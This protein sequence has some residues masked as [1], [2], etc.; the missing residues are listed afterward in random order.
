MLKTACIQAKHW[1]R[2]GLP[3][4]VAVNLS[5]RQFHQVQTAQHARHPLLD[6]V[7]DA[8]DVSG[9]P[10]ALLELEITEGILMRQLDSTMEILNIL[11][12]LGVRISID[13]FGTGYSSLS[14]L[15]RF[16]IDVLKIDKS[17][18]NDITK[19][20]NDKA[21]VS[22][23]TVM[24]Q[25]LKLEVVAEGVESTA[26]MNYLRELRCNYVQ[27][28]FFSKPLATGQVLPFLRQRGAEPTEAGFVA[29][30]RR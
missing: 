25:Q 6:A 21:I 13:D 5:S 7:L 10:P 28:Y 16:P 22:A 23:I 27:G 20:P 12:H 9:L 8:L 3:L 24:A 14:Y 18:V 11:K 30:E 26:Q 19:D 29:V 17:F 1:Q 4:R 15:K 2:A